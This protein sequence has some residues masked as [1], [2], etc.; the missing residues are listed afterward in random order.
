MQNPNLVSQV[1]YAFNHF[2]QYH[3]FFIR[4]IISLLFFNYIL[5]YTYISYIYICL[6]ICVLYPR[7]DAKVGDI[8]RFMYG[9]AL[10]W[11]YL[12][13]IYVVKLGLIVMWCDVV[14]CLIVWNSLK[15]LVA[16]ISKF[17]SVSLI[18][19]NCFWLCYEEVKLRY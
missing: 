15:C 11:F 2:N 1:K 5:I 3:L 12:I 10:L 13:E 4:T 8:I 17:V 18:K 16:L 14:T 9:C 19:W 7:A 6:C